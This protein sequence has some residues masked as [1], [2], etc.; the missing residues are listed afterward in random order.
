[1]SIAHLVLEEPR[2][3]FATLCVTGYNQVRQL[4]EVTL[5]GGRG[6]GGVAGGPP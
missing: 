4:D 6:P 2:M 5:S 3:T 1:M